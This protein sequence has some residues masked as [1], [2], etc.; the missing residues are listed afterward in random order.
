MEYL[1]LIGYICTTN[2][3]LTFM[4][5]RKIFTIILMGI[6]LLSSCKNVGSNN[7]EGKESES[8]NSEVAV[9]KAT[10]SVPD[11]FFGIQFGPMD[12]YSPMEEKFEEQGLFFNDIESLMYGLVHDCLSL[13][14]IPEEDKKFI[15]DGLEWDIVNTRVGNSFYGIDFQ[16]FLNKD[17]NEYIQF[18]KK[19]QSVYS[20][21]YDLQESSSD[22]HGVTYYWIDENSNNVIMLYSIEDMDVYGEYV[23]GVLFKNIELEEKE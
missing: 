8:Q 7:K 2:N 16:R 19:V 20:Q 22:E 11:T 5:T 17:A 21:R 23:V 18:F 13:S 15:Y 14:F 10:V 1:I 12:D 9:T 4:K 3:K 6:A